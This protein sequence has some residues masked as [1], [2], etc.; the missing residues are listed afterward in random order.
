MK[1]KTIKK[2][3]KKGKKRKQ[4]KCIKNDKSYEKKIKVGEQ[5]E[6]KMNTKEK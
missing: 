4:A 3:K 1:K 2:A 5:K 6:S